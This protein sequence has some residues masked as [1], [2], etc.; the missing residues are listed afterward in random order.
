LGQA[1]RDWGNFRKE[2]GDI[3]NA[4]KYAAEASA[5]FQMGGQQ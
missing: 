2:K 1:Y 4:K 5:Y 3:A